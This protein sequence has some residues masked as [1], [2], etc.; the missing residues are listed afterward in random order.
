L[1]LIAEAFGVIG[2]VQARVLADWMACLKGG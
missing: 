1:A 2:G